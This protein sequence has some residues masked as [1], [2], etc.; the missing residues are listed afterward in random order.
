MS[1]VVNPDRAQTRALRA[2]LERAQE[3]SGW[4][5]SP[6]SCVNT[7]PMKVISERLR[8]AGIGITADLYTHLSPELDRAAAE[9]RCSVHFLKAEREFLQILANRHRS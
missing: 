8:H 6:F 7:L 1:E 5:A 4:M 2:G 9:T 3:A